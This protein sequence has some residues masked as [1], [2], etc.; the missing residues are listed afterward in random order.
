[1][2]F[3]LS[4]LWSLQIK[5]LWI[6]NVLRYLVQSAGLLPAQVFSDFDCCIDMQ[7][8]YLPRT[9]LFP[10]I[11]RPSAK[12]I[13]WCYANDTI[14]S[15]CVRMFWD[16]SSRYLE[17][18]R[19]GFHL[20]RWLI[21]LPQ[22]QKRMFEFRGFKSMKHLKWISSSTS[23]G[24]KASWPSARNQ[25]NFSSCCSFVNWNLVD[26]LQVG[27]HHVQQRFLQL[28]GA[29]HTFTS[30]VKQVQ[31]HML[32]DFDVPHSLSQA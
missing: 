7:Q 10:P 1:M 16:E 20:I 4:N 14:V 3:F 27:N 17:F 11:S 18:M 13:V 19:S 8:K 30:W 31:H 15:F 9:L 2:F 21:R 26:K 29:F 28:Y 12:S 5:V 22:Q 23:T 6:G 24:N 32:D 25:L